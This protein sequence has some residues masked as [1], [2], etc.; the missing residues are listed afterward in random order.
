MTHA[1]RT[2]PSSPSSTIAL[3]EANGILIS[4]SRNFILHFI[5]SRMNSNLASPS[6]RLGLPFAAAKFHRLL[7][8]RSLDTFL[9]TWPNVLGRS[10]VHPD[11]HYLLYRRLY[12]SCRACAPSAWTPARQLVHT[13]PEHDVKRLPWPVK[14]LLRVFAGSPHATDHGGNH[15]RYSC[16]RSWRISWWWFSSYSRAE[17]C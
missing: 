8:L 3:T 1:A 11:L 12:S 9:S 4:A 13:R 5:R 10:R 2:R 7:R 14:T 16:H 15:G 6:T 17:G